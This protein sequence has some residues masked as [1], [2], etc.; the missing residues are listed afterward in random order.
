MPNQTKDGGVTA[1]EV[2]QKLPRGYFVKRG[3]IVKAFGLSRAEMDALVPEVFKPAPI[4]KTNAPRARYQT[5]RARFVRSQI[6]A[7]AR[8]WEKPAA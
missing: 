3:D 1:A 8:Q 5:N 6:M 7:I 2:D 4:P